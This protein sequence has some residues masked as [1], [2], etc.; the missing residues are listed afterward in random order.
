MIFGVSQSKTRAL[1]NK[2]GGG[3]GGG[4]HF[5]SIT[6]SI[7]SF[8]WIWADT[9]VDAHYIQGP[10]YNILSQCARTYKFSSKFRTSCRNLQ[11]FTWGNLQLLSMLHC[12]GSFE[13]YTPLCSDLQFLATFVPLNDMMEPTIFSSPGLKAQTILWWKEFKF[14]QMKGNALFQ[15]KIEL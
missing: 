10:I 13:I 3:G 8:K 14:H 12:L 6:R 9:Y 15:G 7:S 11:S 4:Y 2:T 5:V 1:S